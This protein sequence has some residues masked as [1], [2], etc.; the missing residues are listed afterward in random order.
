MSDS[1][2]AK[3]GA[4]GTVLLRYGLAFVSVGAALGL[5]R[6]FLYFHLP[7]PFAAFALSAIAITFWYGGTKPGIVAALLASII[8]YSHWSEADAVSRALYDLVFVIF[9][10]LMT[11]VNRARGELEVKVVQ[12]T[13][14]LTKANENLN[15]EI[16]EHKRA[17][18]K[19]RQSEAYLAEAQSLSH[20]G[21]WARVAATGEMRY[22]SEE[23]YRILGFD[24][25]KEPPPLETFLQHVQPED[26]VMIRELSAAAG[27]AKVDY[28]TDYR[29]TLPGGEIRNIHVLAHP[30]FSSSGD[31]VE[32]VGTVMDVT[33]R[34]QVEEKLRQSEAYLADAQKLTHTGSWVWE[35][36]ERH[37]SH[38][39]EEWYRIY[40]FDPQEGMPAWNKRL[41]R[42]HPDDRAERQESIDRAIREKSDYEIEY[43]VL[44]PGGS[45]RHIHSVGHPV[46]NDSGDLVRFVGSS[47]DITERKQAE[48]ALRQAQ[49]DLARISRITT[50]GELTAS[51]AHEV[52][53]PIAAAVTDA[54]T[55]LRWLAR[56]E[57]DV[58]EA[59][60]AASRTIKDA[61]RA[62]EIIS[63]VRQL[64]KKGTQ[65]RELVDVNEVIRDMVVLLRNETL[66]YSITVRTELA[67]GLP[68]VTAD[69]L[70]LQQVLM[71]LMMNSIDAMK[72]VNATRELAIHSQRGENEHLVI[73]VSDNGV[74][75]P[76]QQADQIFNAFF[77][78][79]PHGTGMGLRISRSIVEAHGGRLWAT[80][81]SP[82]GACFH[83]TL[84]TQPLDHE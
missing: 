67:A 60:A 72:D 1:D 59:R 33:E 79:K 21:S 19:L 12:R 55:C 70:Q 17:E 23:C 45:V 26:R 39:S 56:A 20:T 4:A 10:V 31:L 13:A 66:R 48:E 50:M 71:N 16:A 84:P 36:D 14:E 53:Q 51:L 47:S 37:A 29:I 43:R 27:R 69:R 25:Q 68:Q 64:F 35:V 6:I 62:A 73:S 22:W 58:E 42:I 2:K 15:L 63:R 76:P 18:D 78:T 44:L 32:Y 7:Q 9:A 81:N 83:M 40:G 65:E 61:T 46:S 75:L 38:L 3:W 41:Q 8:R 74:G 80:D 24:P 49:A 34:K 5:A 77:S 28:E 52:N 54:N 57:P 11:G 82:R 30:V